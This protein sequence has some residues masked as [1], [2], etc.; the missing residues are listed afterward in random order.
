MITYTCKNDSTQEI[1]E[2]LVINQPCIIN[3]EKQGKFSQAVLLAKK[4]IILYFY[5]KRSQHSAFE[6]IL[7]I[8]Y[9]LHRWL[10]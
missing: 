4:I 10:Q 6:C 7:Y 2:T 3:K 5:S 1:F 9:A 8:R